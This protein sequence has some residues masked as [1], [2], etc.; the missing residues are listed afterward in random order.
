MVAP[1]RSQETYR[2]DPML[3]DGQVKDEPSRAE[4]RVGWR[5]PSAGEGGKYGKMGVLGSFGS[6]IT[7]L[8]F[9]GP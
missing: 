9:L 4:Q 2:G 7:S 8:N 6:S 5:S 3:V 1:S